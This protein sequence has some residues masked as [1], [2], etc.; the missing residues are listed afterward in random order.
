MDLLDTHCQ[1]LQPSHCLYPP[2]SYSVSQITLALFTT[3]L[4]HI[5]ELISWVL[6]YELLHLSAIIDLSVTI[7]FCGSIKP[8]PLGEPASADLQNIH[9]I[10]EADAFYGF[11]L[12]QHLPHFFRS[13]II[14]EVILSAYPLKPLITI[15]KIS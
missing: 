4:I 2:S 6:S 3:L 5:H 10:S 14:A 8:S 12:G 7:F 13:L 1:Y 11:N 15:L 9:D